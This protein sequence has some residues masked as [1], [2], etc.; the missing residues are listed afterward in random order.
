MELQARF[1]GVGMSA[2]EWLG[3]GAVGG[4]R[5]TLSV[6]MLVRQYGQRPGRLGT[7]DL[8]DVDDH[9]DEGAAGQAWNRRS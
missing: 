2:F 5:A 4:T 7:H 1:H 3:A 6:R 9:I 8:Q